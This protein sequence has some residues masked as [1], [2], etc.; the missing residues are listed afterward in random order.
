MPVAIAY[1]EGF[2]ELMWML[3]DLCIVDISFNGDTGRHFE[4]IVVV[5]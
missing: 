4:K 5:L 2:S 3:D 1:T